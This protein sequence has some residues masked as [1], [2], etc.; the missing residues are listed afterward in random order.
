MK[1]NNIFLILCEG[2]Q[3]FLAYFAVPVKAG[4]S[5]PAADHMEERINLNTAFV[6][7]PLSTFVI[8]CEGDSMINAFIPPKAKLL[9]DQSLTAKMETSCWQHSTENLRSRYSV[10]QS[11]DAGWF[12][13][14]ASKKRSKSPLR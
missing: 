14:T 9:V 1:T 8:D 4:F 13:P 2:P 6:K 10:K 12:L 11:S 5:S 3:T 7:H